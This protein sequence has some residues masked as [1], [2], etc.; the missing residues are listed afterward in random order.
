MR[1]SPCRAQS[2]AFEQGSQHLTLDHIGLLRAACWMRRHIEPRLQ[3]VGHEPVWCLY[4]SPENGVERGGFP[5]QQRWTLVGLRN[6]DVLQL[7]DGGGRQGREVDVRWDAADEPEMQLVSG[8]EER[9]DD[10]HSL[11]LQHGAEL[12]M[13]ISGDYEHRGDLVGRL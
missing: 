7:P 12:F 8:G 3:H 5:D 11:L 9:Q 2:F 10:T 13:G 1:P 6:L 4:R